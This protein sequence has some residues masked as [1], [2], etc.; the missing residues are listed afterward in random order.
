MNGQVVHLGP[1]YDGMVTRVHDRCMELLT[2]ASQGN[3]H[4]TADA[5]ERLV[6]QARA[7]AELLGM[8][9]EGQK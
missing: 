4:A 1:P 9:N 7:L 8:K 5:A 2:V 3:R 6:A